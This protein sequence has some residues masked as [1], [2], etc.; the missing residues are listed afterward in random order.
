MNAKSVRD[1]LASLD[2]KVFETREAVEDAVFPMWA[3]LSAVFH[4]EGHRDLVDRLVSARWVE[5]IQGKWK[6]FLPAEEKFPV[7]PATTSCTP[8][9]LDLNTTTDPHAAKNNAMAA[10][11][12]DDYKEAIRILTTLL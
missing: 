3:K 7:T 11:L 2:G 9:E 12:R 5:F 8:P 1:I 10:V 4:G 6:F